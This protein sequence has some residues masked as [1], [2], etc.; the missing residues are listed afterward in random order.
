M[1]AVP[2]YERSSYLEDI[3]R[4]LGRGLSK[5]QVAEHLHISRATVYRILA[6][7]RAERS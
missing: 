5:A 7:A 6:D 3:K 2:A 4:L 1:S